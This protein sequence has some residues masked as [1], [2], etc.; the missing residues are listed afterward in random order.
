MKFAHLADCHIGGWRDPELKE[1]SI[2][3]FE[4]AVE[5]CIKEYVG[6]VLIA[7][8]L[9]N[10]SLPSIDL[11]KRTAE[12]LNKLKEHE[13]DVYIIPGSHDFSPSG[14]TMLGV[15]EKAGLVIN[16][17]RIINNKLHFVTDKTNVKIT[18]LV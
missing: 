8:D 6:F 7:G 3:A 15:L 16:S 18:G 11:I 1:L 12:I 9:F 14:K 5:I 2:R 10:T 13:I 17:M 4:N